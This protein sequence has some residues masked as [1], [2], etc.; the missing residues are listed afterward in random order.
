M[1][2]G[3]CTPWLCSIP[4]RSGIK[5]EPIEIRNS[6]QYYLIK[7]YIPNVFI[8]NESVI[9]FRANN[10]VPARKLIG[11]YIQSKGHSVYVSLV[12]AYISSKFDK[13]GQPITINFVNK[14]CFRP[15]PKSC[16]WQRLTLVQLAT[17]IHHYLAVSEND[18]SGISGFR[19]ISTR[20]EHVQNVYSPYSNYMDNSWVRIILE[21]LSSDS[22]L[23]C[24]TAC[25]GKAAYCTAVQL[26]YRTRDQKSAVLAKVFV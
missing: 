2:R 6:F 22:T 12:R 8:N 24:E 3:I 16:G 20:D 9:E 15:F 10:N 14:G 4:G 17:S 11:I 7:I 25:I 19:I 23:L 26:F 21:E 13:F 5:S 1:H 18:F